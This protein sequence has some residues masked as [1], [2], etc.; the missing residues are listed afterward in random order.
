MIVEHDMKR[1]EY[2][3]SYPADMVIES[4]HGGPEKVMVLIEVL[5][6]IEMHDNVPKRI[7]IVNCDE[8]GAS[9]A[10]LYGENQYGNWMVNWDVSRP[11]ANI[12]MQVLGQQIPKR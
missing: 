7:A 8:C 3:V 11:L 1:L 12:L 5:T 6:P 9:G 4:N 2:M 10:L